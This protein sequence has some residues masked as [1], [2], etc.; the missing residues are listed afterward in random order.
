MSVR[1]YHYLMRNNP[2]MHSSVEERSLVV[3]GNKEVDHGVH[4]LGCDHPRYSSRTCRYVD[5]NFTEE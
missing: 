5:T 2:E 3:S 4:D 1:N